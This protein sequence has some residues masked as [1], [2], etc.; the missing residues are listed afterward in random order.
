MSMPEDWDAR[1]VDSARI[2]AHR[3]VVEDTDVV[4]QAIDLMEDHGMVLE[5]WQAAAFRAIMLCDGDVIVSSPSQQ[6]GYR[7]AR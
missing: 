2:A 4:E 6:Y 3:Q 1:T 5:P 7:R